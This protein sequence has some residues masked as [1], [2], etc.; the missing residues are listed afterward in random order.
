MLKIILII[1]IINIIYME[2]NFEQYYQE[3]FKDIDS[4]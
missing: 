3:S 1:D 4:I 2:T